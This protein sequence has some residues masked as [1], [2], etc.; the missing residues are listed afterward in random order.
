MPIKQR[1]RRF[2]GPLSE[3]IDLEISNLLAKGIIE[4]S[5]LATLVPIRKKGNI[6]ICVDYRAVNS[7][8]KRDSFP[9]PNLSDAIGQFKDNKYFSSLDLLSRYHQV[10]LEPESREITAFSTG[11]QLYQFTKLPFGVTNG[12]A[13]F[14][15]LMSVVLS[16]VPCDKVQVYLDD[17]LV[18]GVDFEDHLSNLGLVLGC[19]ES[20]A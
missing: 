6:T 17:I 14:S 18:V 9:L 5:T 16:G 4:P 11:N 7:V 12:P 15:R 2:L 20:I 1:Y 10:A 3:K 19:F 8:T 13:T